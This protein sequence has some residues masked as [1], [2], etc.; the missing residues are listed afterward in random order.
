MSNLRGRPAGKPNLLTRQMKERAAF[1]GDKALERIVKLMDSEDEAVS[2]RA[3][4]ELLDRGFGKPAQISI[5]QGDE[6]GGPVRT[7]KVERVIVKH[8]AANT[9]G[10]GIRAVS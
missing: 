8:D 6:D 1:W 4:S 10:A 9:N 2:L 5:L 7:E 3:C